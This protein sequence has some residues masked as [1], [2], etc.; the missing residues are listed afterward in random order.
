MQKFI[1]VT[2]GVLSGLGK[3]VTTACIGKILQSQGFSVVPIKFDGYVNRDAGTMNPFEHGEVY[4][5]DDGGEIDLDLGHYERFLNLDLGKDNNI[6]N[7]KVYGS[8]IEK[9]R[10]GDYLGKTVQ[11]IPH[12]TDEIKRRIKFVAKKSKADIVLI[13]IGGTVGD[14]ENMVCI[15]AVRQMKQQNPEDFLFIHL[16]LVPTLWS[17]EQ[18]TKPTQRSVKDLQG[19]GLQPDIVVCRVTRSLNKSMKRKIAL[20]C[21]V[22][23]DCV[24]SNPDIKLLYELPLVFEKQGMSNIVLKKLGLKKK[25]KDMKGW[26][27]LVEKAKGLKKEISIGIVGKYAHLEDAYLSIKESLYHAGLA[28]DCKVR[29]KWIEAEDIEEEGA[30]KHLKDINGMIV[31]GGFGIRGTEGK[32]KAIE[33]ARENNVPF[34]GICYGLHMAIIEFARNVCDMKNANTSENVKGTKCPVIDLMEEQKKIKKLGGTMRLGAYE[35]ALK[36]GTLAYKLYKKTK[37]SQR[38]RHRWEVNEKYVKQLEK[39]GLV[40]SGR[41]PKTGL[42]EIVEIPSKKYFIAGQFHPEFKSRPEEPEPLFD[43]LVKASLK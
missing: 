4:V 32:I 37:I 31:P 10:N 12:V 40:V 21:S 7:G 22:P 20:F 39:N 34:L 18:K 23:D 3:G 2:G 1:V 17:G 41:N 9:E 38:H 11:I 43:G 6:T 24:I 27:R 33:Y 14:I 5:T 42:V 35:C 28:N 8:V 29:I 30:E 19:L 16:T 26:S 36:K 15:E 13:E 25:K